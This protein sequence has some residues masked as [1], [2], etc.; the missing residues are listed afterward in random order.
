MLNRLSEIY[1]AISLQLYEQNVRIITKFKNDLIY[2]R[3]GEALVI[4]VVCFV[5]FFYLLVNK[6]I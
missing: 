2:L 4:F 1:K 3:I 5:F 6:E